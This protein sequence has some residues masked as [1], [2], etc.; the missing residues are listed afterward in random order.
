MLA[1]QNMAEILIN[2]D[3]LAPHLELVRLCVVSEHLRDLYTSIF[4]RAGLPLQ[5]QTA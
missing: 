3:T 4:E 1:A 5:G 2:A